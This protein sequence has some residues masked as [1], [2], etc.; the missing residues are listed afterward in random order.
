MGRRGAHRGGDELHRAGGDRRRAGP[1]RRI[2]PEDPAHPRPRRHQRLRHL[3][4]PAH[5]PGLDLQSAP[6]RACLLLVSPRGPRRRHQ[7]D[8]RA[9]DRHDAR[10]P[11]GAEHGGRRRGR[12]PRLRRRCGPG[13]RLPARRPRHHRQALRRLWRAGGR[14]RLQ[15]RLDPGLPALGL[16]AAALPRRHRCRHLLCHD[17]AQRHE[18]HRR[19]GETGISSPASSSSA[20]VSAASWSPIS[21]RCAS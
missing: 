21:I 20:S 14:A 17:L 1:C 11:L 15:Q 9:D 8:L 13:R 2:A 7:L 12:A 18:R 4:P 6:R 5:R 3:F 10:R 16:P 19:D